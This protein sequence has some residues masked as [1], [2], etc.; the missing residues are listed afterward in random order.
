MRRKECWK[1]HIVELQEE[2][3]EDVQLL[4]KYSDL[5]YGGREYMAMQQVMLKVVMYVKGRENHRVEIRF[6]YYL[7]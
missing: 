2:I 4:G 1:I 5:D 6:H 3:M 7:R